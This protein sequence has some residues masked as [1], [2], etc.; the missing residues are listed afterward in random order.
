MAV[1]RVYVEKKPGFRVE[2]GGLLQDLRD[3]LG[4]SALAEVRILHRYDIDSISE[5]VYE[6]AMGRI[7]SEA[8]VDM[9]SE[10]D[11]EFGGDTKVFAVEYLPGQYD[12]RADSAQQCIQ[13]LGAE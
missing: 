5:E 11:V 8:P 13:I 2:A 3:N 4:L 12:Q 10:E 7:L 9:V 6:R 1:K